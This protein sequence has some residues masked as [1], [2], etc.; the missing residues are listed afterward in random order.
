MNILIIGYGVVG[1]N[2]QKLFPDAD[3]YDCHMKEH[4]TKKDKKY[5][6]AFVCVP[7]EKKPD[8]S[9]DI[10]IVEKVVMAFDNVK[11]FCI[12]STVPPGTTHNLNKAGYDC[13]F[14]PE[15][16]GGT[17]HANGSDYNFVIL[18]GNRNH[19]AVVA[20][21]YKEIMTGEFRIIQTTATTAEL[22]KYMEN[23]WLALKVSFC[24]E[25]SRIAEM[26]GIDNNELREL[27]LMDPRVGR[28]HT[29]VYEDH[30]FY[31]SH[32][33]NKD[34]PGI[35]RASEEKGYTPGL[36]KA[37]MEINDFYKKRLKK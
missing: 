24:C 30:P 29:F 6:L 15:Y 32:C 16:F 14:S 18:G 20:E 27:W 11:I 37:M 22:C 28:S 21:A 19:S 3:I 34:V 35:I 9:C 33:L 1:K 36:L 13:V 25:F 17:Q 12:K 10:S 7:T 8:G 2:M 5:D 26:F 4:A 23:A 31:D